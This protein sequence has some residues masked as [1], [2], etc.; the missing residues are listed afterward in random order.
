MFLDERWP[1]KSWPL[2]LN[3]QH[4]L[5]GIDT[6]FELLPRR[7]GAVGSP[8]AIEVDMR[9]CRRPRDHVDEYFT[10]ALVVLNNFLVQRHHLQPRH[11]ELARFD[12]AQRVVDDRLAVG[13]AQRRQLTRHV[14]SIAAVL[15]TVLLHGGEHAVARMRWLLVNRAV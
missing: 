4:N 1:K 15:V 12:E 11:V 5:L 10:L 14:A 8:P 3:H 2:V 13:E 6:Q 9:R 7:P